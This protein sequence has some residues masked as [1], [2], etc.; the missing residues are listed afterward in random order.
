MRS[1]WVRLHGPVLPQ[2]PSHKPQHRDRL[3]AAPL[4]VQRRLGHQCLKCYL[5]SSCNNWIYTLAQTKKC[6]TRFSNQDLLVTSSLTLTSFLTSPSFLN[7]CSYLAAF[8]CLIMCRF[9][10]KT[11]FQCPTT[12]YGLFSQIHV[13]VYEPHKSD[14]SV[15]Y[16]CL[17]SAE[18]QSHKQ[19]TAAPATP[20]VA[21]PV[22]TASGVYIDVAEDP[23]IAGECMPLPQDPLTAAVCA[24]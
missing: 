21:S 22:K 10:G 13:S 18:N 17:L 1:L 4:Q 5:V 6:V 11:Q 14:Q 3:K 2:G 15:H 8:I 7:L 23:L 19:N 16:P 12:N 24:L 20:A 9:P